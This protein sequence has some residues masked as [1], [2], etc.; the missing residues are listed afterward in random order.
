MNRQELL[1]KI[2]PC[3]LMCYTCSAF[4]RGII[5][6]L[7]KELLN[8]TEGMHEFFEKHQA[9][10]L[11]QFEAFNNEL[12]NYSAGLCSGCRNREHHGCSIQGCFILECT[13]SQNV[14][15]CGECK[16]FPCDKVKNLFEQEVYNLWLLGNQE[17]KEKG[18]ECFWEENKC[19]SHYKQ[20]K[21]CK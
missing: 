8:Y 19:K 5:C 1:D 13:K 12:K 6:G 20:Y 11:E 14:D 17:I 10:N 9:P 7:S 21:N 4:E 18:I 15:Y 3:S 16:A 2:A